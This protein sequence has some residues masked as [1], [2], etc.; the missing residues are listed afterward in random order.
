MTA[1]RARSSAGLCQLGATRLGETHLLAI[2]ASAD[3]QKFTDETFATC[4]VDIFL[5]PMSPSKR[6]DVAETRRQRNSAFVASLRRTR[7]HCEICTIAQPG[8]NWAIN[9]IASR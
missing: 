4:D 5:Q 9:P 8:M 6:S 7:I 1:K 2:N 3:F